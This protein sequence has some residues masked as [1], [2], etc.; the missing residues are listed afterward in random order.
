MLGSTF[1]ANVDYLLTMQGQYPTNSTWFLFHISFVISQ[2]F[3]FLSWHR[4]S[5]SLF[6]PR[7]I[8]PAYKR[9]E[10][11]KNYGKGCINLRPEVIF[12]KIF[13]SKGFGL[14]VLFIMS[15][16]Y[17]FCLCQVYLHVFGL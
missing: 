3:H 11:A 17:V 10:L 16:Y 13:G 15:L 1:I 14:N 9:V 6:G 4:Q 8:A 5:I 7:G 2:F 12:D